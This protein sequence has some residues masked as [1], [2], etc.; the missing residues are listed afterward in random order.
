MK[1]NI[2]QNT[3]KKPKVNKDPYYMFAIL[4]LLVILAA[5][6]IINDTK[7]SY[8]QK[9]NEMLRTE[10]SLKSEKL[11]YIEKENPNH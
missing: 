4:L 9:E 2:P 1:T 7:N 11:R 10:L 5:T 3:Y 8:I 6:I